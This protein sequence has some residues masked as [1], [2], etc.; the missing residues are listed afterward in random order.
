[1]LSLFSWLFRCI[2]CSTRKNKDKQFLD[3]SNQKLEKL[4]RMNQKAKRPVSINTSE[5]SNITNHDTSLNDNL[6]IID[7]YDQ[8]RWSIQL[9]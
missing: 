6:E 4:E 9:F 1:M 3:L 8:L 5:A 2:P 7:T